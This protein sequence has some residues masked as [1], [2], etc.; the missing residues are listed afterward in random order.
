MVDPGEL[1]ATKVDGS[2][3]EQS[4]VRACFRTLLPQGVK[5][6]FLQMVYAEK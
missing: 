4:A 6:I 2:Q 5:E 1:A 3:K